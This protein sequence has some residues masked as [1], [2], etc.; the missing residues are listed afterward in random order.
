LRAVIDLGR[1]WKFADPKAVE[2]G[3]PSPDPALDWQAFEAG[4]APDGAL[5][6]VRQV[7]ERFFAARPAF[8]WKTQAE[9]LYVEPSGR[10][11]RMGWLLSRR[12]AQPVRSDVDAEHGWV[13]RG[14]DVEAAVART[15]PEWK[16]SRTE[17]TLMHCSDVGRAMFAPL[18]P[19][20]VYTAHET[21]VSTLGEF[22]LIWALQVQT[23]YIV[24]RE[25]IIESEVPGTHPVVEVALA[26][27]N[28]SR[29]E[30]GLSD[31]IAGLERDAPG[32]TGYDDEESRLRDCIRE[33]ERRH[34]Y[35]P[36]A[37]L[38]ALSEAGV[39]GRVEEIWDPRL[40]MLTRLDPDGLG[41]AA[42]KRLRPIQQK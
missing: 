39:A 7:L 38:G 23:R 3:Y 24:V 22:L 35:E 4:P 25:Q 16:R 9:L 18:K 31:L 33:I 36:K 17:F 41:T 10:A 14:R 11:K 26:E 30:A 40:S 37:V 28:M 5:P 1:D 13:L 20:D 29:L 42:L 34:H 6:T 8:G 19:V 15:C 32:L 12:F 21:S 2:E 27:W